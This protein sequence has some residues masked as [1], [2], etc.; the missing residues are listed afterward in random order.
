MGVVERAIAPSVLAALADTP[1]V[2]VNGARQVG[3]TTLVARLDYPGSSEVVSLDDVANRDAA[4]DDP[5]AFVSRP[6]DTLVIDEAQLEPGLFRAIK[7][8]VDRDRRPGRFLLTGSARLLSAPDMADA[9]VG[10]VEIIELWPFSQGERAGIADG[11][12]DALFTAPRELIHGSDM[13]RADLVDRIA[14]GGF[15]DIV[16]RSPSRR[17]AWFDNYLT[18]ATQSVIREILPIERLAEMPRVLRLCA[19]R[20]GAELNVSA[21]ANDLSIPARTTAGYLALLEAAFL[22]HRVPAW[23]TNLS[24][25]VIRRPKL[26]VSDS[27]LACHLLGVTGATLD[28]PGR[29]LGPL[30]E[31]FVAN[32][33]RKQLTWSTERPSLWHFRDR[34]GAEVDLVLEHPDGRAA[35]SRSRRPARREPRTCVAYVIWPSGS[36]I[37]FSSACCSPPR[38]KPPR[39]AQRSRRYPL[40]RSG[41]ANSSNKSRHFGIGGLRP[42]A[43]AIYPDGPTIAGDCGH[44]SGRNLRRS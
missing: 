2:V 4:R 36:M 21:L 9:L 39:S 43:L 25:K 1:V 37:D 6:V 31:T 17:R 34:G 23:S 16:A 35:A 12:V 27:G 20:T 8:E 14:T 30:L 29:P 42:G 38:R 41:P 11:F 3:K 18:T 5:R 10:R 40:A 32:E 24:R 44:S 26:V 19:A 13:R 15:P 7:A 28:R 33:I 22:I